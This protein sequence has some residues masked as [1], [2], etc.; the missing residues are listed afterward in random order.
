M[1]GCFD[2][3]LVGTLLGRDVGCVDGNGD[4]PV[5][6]G[7]GPL[8][9]RDDGAR[10]FD[11]RGVGSSVGAIVGGSTEPVANARPRVSAGAIVSGFTESTGSARLSVGCCA[12]VEC[13]AVATVMMFTKCVRMDPLSTGPGAPFLPFLR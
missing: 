11:G 4:G 3:W 6:C 13:A 9:G 10:V 7:V 12:S 5:G 2:G 8:F 1:M